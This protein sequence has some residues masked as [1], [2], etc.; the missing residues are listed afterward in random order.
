L[1]RLVD[2]PVH[3]LPASWLYGNDLANIHLPVGERILSLCASGFVIA[4]GVVILAFACRGRLESG[5]IGW[6]VFGM[7]SLAVTAAPISWTHYQVLNYP[8]V[9]LLLSRSVERRSPPLLCFD[10]PGPWAAMP[11]AT[12][13]V[14]SSISAV[15]GL[16]LFALFIVMV[17]AE[18]HA[19]KTA[20]H[21]ASAV[22]P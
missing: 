12:I 14:W 21:E 3:G 22:A 18:L 19:G 6:A 10:V 13:Y 2:R 8:G 11:A 16:I 5:P 4:A 1:L 17:W 20:N 9:A 15:A 7:I